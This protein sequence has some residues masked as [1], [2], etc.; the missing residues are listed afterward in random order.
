[1]F[2]HCDCHGTPRLHERALRAKNILTCS[3]RLKEGV[4][5][6]EHCNLVASDM[7]IAKQAHMF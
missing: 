6:L 5:I 3:G 2:C 1:M 4:F 7:K